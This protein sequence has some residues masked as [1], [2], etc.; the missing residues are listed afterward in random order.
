M[1]TLTFMGHWPAT[2]AV[3]GTDLYVSIPLAGAAGDTHGAGNHESHC[4]GDSATCTDAPMAA[5]AGLAML[6]D[7]V[8]L[9]S[10]GGLFL[11]L[12]GRLWRPYLAITL[13]P[14]I[15]PPEHHLSFG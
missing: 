3:P 2:V 6:S 5:G 4:H 9:A 1:P 8:V 13:A 14:E 7:T 10:L 12:T 11:A 15:K